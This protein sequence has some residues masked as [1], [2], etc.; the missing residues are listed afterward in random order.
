MVGG[1]L[2]FV[3]LG[4]AVAQTSAPDRLWKLRNRYDFLERS[5]RLLTT[6]YTDL[7][8]N[9]DEMEGRLVDIATIS[10]GR[11]TT[12]PGVPLSTSDRSNQ[13]TIYFTPYMGNNIALFN[14]TNWVVTA[15]TELSLVLSG[16]TSGQNHDIFIYNNAGTVTI[17]TPTA[18]TDSVTRATALVAQDGV[19]VKSGATTRRYVGTIRATSTTQTQDTLAQRFVWNYQNRLTKKLQV[20]EATNSWTYV[21]NGWRSAN[22]SVNNRVEFVLG[23]SDVLVEARVFNQIQAGAG[24]VNYYANGV[25]LDTTTNVSSQ[26]R[27]SGAAVNII[28]QVWSD[29]KDYPGLGYHFL[30]W[31]ERSN[32]SSVTVYGD[33]GDATSYQGGLL[34]EFSG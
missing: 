15:F 6:A 29:Y 8:R 31:V 33:N 22:T 12:E 27:G 20:L 10:E 1:A 25:G 30:Q 32:G 34:G 16:L 24:T 11:L 7:F 9:L 13:T 17:D 3:F 21:T 14:G 5:L 19:W 23:Q 26:V 28:N 2:A 4:S 18:W